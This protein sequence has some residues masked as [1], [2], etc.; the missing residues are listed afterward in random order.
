MGA[1]FT[2]A[3]RW[4]QPK[5]P[6]MDEWIRKCDLSIQGTII[7][8]KTEKRILTHTT[9]WVS[10]EDIMLRDISQTYTQKQMLYDSIFTRYLE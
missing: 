5:C 1:V 7:Q 4:K 10:L 8:P 9:T 3:K 2:I 6:L